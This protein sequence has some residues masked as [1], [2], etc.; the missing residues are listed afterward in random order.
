LWGRAGVKSTIN[1]SYNKLDFLQGS[2]QNALEVAGHCLGI[3]ELLI[4]QL[5]RRLLLAQE[6]AIYASA[7]LSVVLWAAAMASDISRV[8]VHNR[9]EAVFCNLFLMETLE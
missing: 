2:F 7:Y 8:V 5:P 3:V 4:K 1:I 9:R 6:I